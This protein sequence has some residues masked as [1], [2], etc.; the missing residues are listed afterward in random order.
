MA[1]A[2]KTIGYAD[3]ANDQQRTDPVVEA[4]GYMPAVLKAVE[5]ASTEALKHVIASLHGLVYGT[6]TSAPRAPAATA[7]AGAGARPTQTTSD[8]PD[9]FNSA[10]A[11]SNPEQALVAGYWLSVVQDQN[12]SSGDV[13]KLLK[14]VSV[15]LLNPSRVFTTLRRRS[16][17][18]LFKDGDRG[19]A[20]LY[21]LT[22]DGIAEVE[23]MIPG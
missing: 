10:N 14:T 3:E 9:F 11:S 21:R 12:F 4:R 20:H 6:E 2:K 5:G 22:K 18:V 16:P 23:K 7:A 1:N 19:P 15:S 13:N 8:F 17:K